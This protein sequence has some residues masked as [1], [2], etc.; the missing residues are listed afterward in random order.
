M[1]HEQFIEEES[2]LELT[3]NSVEQLGTEHL[4]NVQA[5]REK[6]WQLKGL[7]R[8]TNGE[9][10]KLVVRHVTSEEFYADGAVTV[11]P[12]RRQPSES[13]EHEVFHKDERYQRI[14][15][16]KVRGAFWAS[17]QAFRANPRIQGTAQATAGNAGQG[18]ADYAEWHNRNEPTSVTA[19]TFTP[20]TASEVK[21]AALRARGA[22]IH[23]HD[24]VTKERYETLHDA[25]AGA[26]RFVESRTQEG[27]GDIALLDPYAHPDTIAGQGTIM[28]ETYAQL[29]DAGVDIL[30]KPVRVRVGGGGFGLAIG[31]AE[32]LQALIDAGMIHPGS[33]VEATQEEHTDSMIR[34]LE[35]LQT[36]ESVDLKTLFAH[37]YFSAANDGTAV[38]IPDINNVAAAY[39]LMQRGT[40]GVRRITKPRVASAMRLRPND[41]DLEPAGSLGLAS[42]LEDSSTISGYLGLRHESLVDVIVLSGGN[43]SQTTKEEYTAALEDRSS[44]IAAMG[45]VVTRRRIEVARPV[46]VDP[47]VHRIFK[48]QLG[49]WGVE[50]LD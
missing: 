23:D 9:R 4:Q 44:S 3:L 14:R 50:L 11:T 6:L 45:S 15:S 31:C 43:V 8:P 16:F 47:A 20:H 2:S 38:E 49:D 35:L 10:P 33:Y 36:H 29:R 42:Y 13:A 24:P 39:L 17:I 5:S 21:K 22:T 12:L 30:G 7:Q 26:R 32:A 19:H 48:D 25:K 37:D 28:L 1:S 18:G 41:Q 34:A 46:A 40:L 27:I